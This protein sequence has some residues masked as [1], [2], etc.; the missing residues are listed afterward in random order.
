MKWISITQLLLLLFVAV[1]APACSGEGTTIYACRYE[2]RTTDGCDG[3]GFGPWES[4]C[5]E[6][7]ADDYYITP[8]EVC[9]NVTESG[10]HCQAGCCVDFD[11]QNVDLEPGGC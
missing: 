10:L 3:Y 6:F 5:Y 2:E 7:D 9:G 1:L 11:Y 4:A 8:Q